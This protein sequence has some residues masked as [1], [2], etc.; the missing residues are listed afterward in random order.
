MNVL[1]TGACGFIGRYIAMEFRQARHHITGVGHGKWAAGE[2]RKWGIS[3]WFETTITV[4]ALLKMNQ[5]FDMIVHCGGSG[6]VGFSQKTPYEDFQKN[7]QSTLSVLE[8]IRLQSPGCKMIY[9][10]SPAV[11][12]NIGNKPITEEMKSV[13]VSPYG[14]HKKIAEELCLS[15]HNNFNIDIGIIRFFS[16]YGNGLKKQ[17]LWDACRKIQQSEEVMFH[18]TGNET[19]DWIHISDACSL[20]YK[21]AL[22]CHGFQVINGGSGKSTDIKTVINLLCSYFEKEPKISFN[23]T[24]KKGDPVYF[25]ADIS[26]A[27]LLG[28]QPATDFRDGLKAYVHYF[29]TLAE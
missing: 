28:W 7:V 5:K 23:G 2:F 25:L 13:P 24:V 9:P 12:G 11:Q 6:S 22:D 3:E 18:G 26:R 15:Y 1:V 19:R 17:L 16:V 21:F 8:Y 27:S 20:L 4:E 10:S 14:F 29:R